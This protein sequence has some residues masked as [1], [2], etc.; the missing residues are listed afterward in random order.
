VFVVFDVLALD[1][2]ATM[3]LP[4]RQ[5]RALLE[6]LDVNGNL[7]V[8]SPTFVDGGALFQAMERDA[9]EGIVAKP[10]ERGW[11]KVKKRNY[12]RFGEERELA[13]SRRRGRVTF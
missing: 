3:H 11:V 4:Y 8:T 6:S 13:A 2:E 1:S 10:G 9:L 7:W 5:R 12:W